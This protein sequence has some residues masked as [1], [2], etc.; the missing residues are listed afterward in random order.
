MTS[1]EGDGEGAFETEE[2]ISSELIASTSFSESIS[3][4]D[5]GATA[6]DVELRLAPVTRFCIPG[7]VT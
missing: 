2:A 4:T 3:E 1:I 6:A 5:D 7:E